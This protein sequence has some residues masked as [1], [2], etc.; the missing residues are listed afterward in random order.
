M[1]CGSPRGRSG[2]GTGPGGLWV[3][4]NASAATLTGRPYL[5]DGKVPRPLLL[6]RHVGRGPLA[7]PAAQVLALS[8]MDWNTDACTAACPPRSATCR[9]SPTSSSTRRCRPSRTTT[10]C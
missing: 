6:T 7:E 2:A 8:K 9:S 1:T 4:Y 3:A 10:A 5:Q